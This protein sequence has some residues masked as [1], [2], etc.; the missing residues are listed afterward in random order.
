VHRAFFPSLLAGLALAL[1]APGTARAQTQKELAAARQAFKE[2]DEAEARGDLPTALGRF[3]AALAVK[4]TPQL[5]LRVGVV[6]EKMGK[7]VDALAAYEKARDK[8][9]ALPAVAKVAKEQIESV[10]PRIPTLTVSVTQSPPGLTVTLDGA[11]FKLDAAVPL[12]PGTHRLHAEAPGA[13]P[14]DQE[15]VATERG[16]LRVD[17]DFAPRAPVVPADQASPS[18]A[19]GVVL[20]AAGIAAVAGGAALIGVSVSK[21]KAIDALCG[22]ATRD[23]CPASKKDEILSDVSTVNAM[24]FSGIAVGVLGAASAVT[25]GILL[26]RALKAP[27]TTGLTV[28]PMLGPGVAGALVGGRF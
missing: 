11:P 19:P 5:H 2:G 14:R 16:V 3:Q 21:D 1:L 17:L 12:D 9:A 4:A 7:L 24:R 8:A 23:R 22:S 10:K 28:T 20:L 15:V 26:S 13:A 27:S 25:G 18:K 6:L